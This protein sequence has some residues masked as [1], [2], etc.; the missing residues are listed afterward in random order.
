M[1]DKKSIDRLFQEKFKEFEAAPPVGSW[2][3]IHARL[4]KKRH[5]KPLILWWIS[6]AVIALLLSIPLIDLGTNTPLTPAGDTQSRPDINQNGTPIASEAEHLTPDEPLQTRPDG[7]PS[8]PSEPETTIPI[9]TP[10]RLTNAVAESNM[11]SGRMHTQQRNTE[12]FEVLNKNQNPNTQTLDGLSHPLAQQH[13]SKDDTDRR[14]DLIAP[15]SPTGTEA[16]T[17]SKFTSPDSGLA[18]QSTDTVN[19]NAVAD[20]PG[21]LLNEKELTALVSQ[22]ENQ[23]SR[24]QL[25][26]RVA[27]IYFN[28]HGTGSALDASLAQSDRHYK[29]TVSMGIGLSYDL[30]KRWAVRTGINTLQLEYET[31]NL[32]FTQTISARA[33]EHGD[34]NAAGSVLHIGQ[35]APQIPGQFQVSTSSKINGN[36]SHRT[37][38]IEWPLE[39][40]Y[41]L[42]DK[43]FGIDIIGGTSALFLQKNH[44]VLVGTQTQMTIGRANNLNRTHFSSNLGI[45]L[46]YEIFKKV[47]LSLEP[48]LKYQFSTYSTDVDFNPY[49]F[50]VYSGL[51]YRF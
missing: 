9:R 15:T 35:D 49:F 11:P 10:K 38:Y 7:E 24:W 17:Q 32:A 6:A 12:P 29:T 23:V 42:L 8:M 27:P 13:P 50:G 44:L 46:H 40:S 2:E 14:P 26:S 5:K 4:P 16:N 21:K 18:N 30:G 39:V 19:A 28:A 36:L 22:G 48:T 41:R 3:D 20:S 37:A 31:R 25:Q 33:L 45:G 43:R 51:H 34:M 47:N 1:R